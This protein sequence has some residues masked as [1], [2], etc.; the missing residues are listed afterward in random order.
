MGS[1]A[2]SIAMGLTVI[3]IRDK[4]QPEIM[5][6]NVIRN[7]EETES[8]SHDIICST[9]SASKYKDLFGSFSIC[10]KRREGSIRR[11]VVIT[12]M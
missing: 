2:Y 5:I 1:C 8:D 10:F 7:A 6:A 11:F 9:N 4:S 12:S 3:F